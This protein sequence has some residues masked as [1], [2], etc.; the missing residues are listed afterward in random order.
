MHIVL[1]EAILVSSGASDT[2]E[3]KVLK[4]TDWGTPMTYLH[5]MACL[6]AV[7]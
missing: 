6:N 7:L 4:V 3:Y 1:G 5:D 2:M